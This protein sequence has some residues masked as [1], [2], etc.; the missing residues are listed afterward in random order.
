MI[1]LPIWLG[2]L[3]LTGL[4]MLAI[5]GGKTSDKT[6]DTRFLTEIFGA[7]GILIGLML[8]IVGLT[9]SVTWV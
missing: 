9:T 7:M 5:M 8:T 2:G 3:I 6:S 4:S 1:E